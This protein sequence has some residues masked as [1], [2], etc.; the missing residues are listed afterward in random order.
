MKLYELDVI[1]YNGTIINTGWKTGVYAQLMKKLKRPTTVCVWGGIC[2]LNFN[3]L[4]FQ[5]LFQILD[6]ETPNSFS[7]PIP[8]HLNKC[9]KLKL[10]IFDVVEF[11]IPEINRRI[12]SKN[13]YWILVML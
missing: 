13:T 2:L 8:T 1:G 3:E 7:G 12:L 5:H 10:L 6:D 9:Y 11:V 4:P